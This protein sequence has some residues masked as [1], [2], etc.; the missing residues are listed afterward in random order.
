MRIPALRGLI[1]RRI[2][3]NFRVDPEVIQ[4]QLPAPFRPKLVGDSA[5][6]G[7]CLIRLEQIRPRFVSWPVGLASENAAHRVAVC[8]TDTLGRVEEGVYVPRR[9]SNSRWNQ[10][11][12]GRLFPGE[13]HEATF[14]VRDNGET[15]GLTMQS[16]DGRV[17]VELK[18]HLAVS[19]PRTSRFA[20]VGEASAFFERGS[21][22]YSAKAEA[23]HL[24]GLYLCTQDWRVEPLEVESVQ[25]SYF[26]DDRLFPAGSVQFDSA[27]L[28]R[29]IPH[30][31]RSAP[32]LPVISS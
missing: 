3:V 30:E 19:L 20:S 27:L 2:L 8:W 5:M 13:H 22:G 28:M 17:T 29:N 24:D 25:S 1:R 14:D 4:R 21:L 6:A 15:I 26:T 23:G 16:K 18:A 7:I 11:A 31:W 12:G 9:D 10:L 32:E